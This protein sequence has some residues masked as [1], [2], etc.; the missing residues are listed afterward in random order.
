[1]ET[2]GSV[3]ESKYKKVLYI[4][5]CLIVVLV[6][7]ICC[8]YKKSSI[9]SNLNK[10]QQRQ[11]YN[12]I[13][14]KWEVVRSSSQLGEKYDYIK[15]QNL[16]KGES[17]DTSK[18][19]GTYINITPEYIE[20]EKDGEIIRFEHYEI[21]QRIDTKLDLLEL[22]YYKVNREGNFIEW[23]KKMLE[24]KSYYS[25]TGLIF[26][27]PFDPSSIIV[28]DFTV[29]DDQTLIAHNYNNTVELRRV[30]HIQDAEIYYQHPSSTYNQKKVRSKAILGN[31]HYI[32]EEI[33]NV[34]SNRNPMEYLA[35]YGKWKVKKIITHSN[36]IYMKEKEIKRLIGTDVEMDEGWIKVNGRVVSTN[37]K[38]Q[39]NVIPILS[40]EQVY[41]EGHPTLNELGINGDYFIYIE[42]ISGKDNEVY[43]EPFR[44]IY[45]KDKETIIVEEEG[46]YLELQKINDPKDINSFYEF[47]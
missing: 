14:G 34:N 42:I 47:G 30:E 29:I 6:I 7:G 31:K 33:D 25:I 18:L 20:Y 26:D 38:A 1:M 35:I 4:I 21:M 41:M 23:A 32:E 16:D 40:K 19:I 15:G 22:I 11:S 24:N 28:N 2:D 13:Y 9:D 37:Y 27:H 36:Q 43:N 46:Y 39:I 12:I 10:I 44:K 8:V 45:I 5:V 17:N 3:K